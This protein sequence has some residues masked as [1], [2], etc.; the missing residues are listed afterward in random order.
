MESTL[1]PSPIEAPPV[2]PSFLLSQVGGLAA[3]L[4]A[5]RLAELGLKPYH[6]GIVRIVEHNPGISQQT[7]SHALGVF[8]SQLVL[9]LDALERKRLVERRPSADDRRRHRLH[10]TAAGRKA[11]RDIER[12]TRDLEATLFAKLSATDV[13]RLERLLRRV[14]DEVGLTPSVHPAYGDLR[15]AAKRSV[16]K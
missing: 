13:V 14:G 12:L 7:L 9:L 8:A 1:A 3:R 6:A 4:F 16:R 11:A 15:T 10:L 5:E 2:G